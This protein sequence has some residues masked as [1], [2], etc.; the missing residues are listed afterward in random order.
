MN[1]CVN[2]GGEQFETTLGDHSYRSL[3]GTLLMNIEIRTCTACGERETVIPAIEDLNGFLVRELLSKESHLVGG[4]VRFLRKSLGWSGGDFASHFEMRPE[5]ISRIE[6]DRH[7]IS[8]RLDKML[9]MAVVHERRIDD[10]KLSDLLK[11]R[12]EASGVFEIRVSR[13]GGKWRLTG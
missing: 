1:K 7:P 8:P 5:T 12:R 10:Y 4:E 6:N 13:D 2:C 3:P 11:K 9:R